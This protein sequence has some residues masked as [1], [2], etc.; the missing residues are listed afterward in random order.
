M[1]LFTAI[2]S[3]CLLMLASN[4]SAAVTKIY[5]SAAGSD[6]NNGASTST[7]VKSLQ[8]VQSLLVTLDPDDDV[9]VHIAPGTYLGQTVYWN[10]LNGHTITFTSQAFG[11]TRPV[12]DGQG[13]SSTWFTLASALGLE[14]NLKFRYIQVQNYLT[15]IYFSGNREETDLSLGWNGHNDLYGMMIRR[16]GGKYTTSSTDYSTAAVRLVNSRNNTISNSHF[17]YIENAAPAANE[18]DFRGSIHAVYMAHRSS[19]NLIQTSQFVNV[20]GDPI[21]V[22]D[23]SD[24]NQIESNVFTNSGAYAYSEWYCDISRTDCTS[25]V[26]E[27]PSF[28]NLVRNNQLAGSYDGGGL[29]TFVLSGS[30]PNSCPRVRTSGNATL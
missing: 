3:A 21:R 6:A 8:R 12:F 27:C 16:I 28:G 2:T 25:P 14:T 19:N 9:E 1:R 7:P 18:T 24:Y 13:A 15:A 5:M 23:S 30:L 10:Y 20:S 11:S 4:D 22:R 17:V 26:Y 29:G